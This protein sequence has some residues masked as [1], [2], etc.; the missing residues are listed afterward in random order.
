MGVLKAPRCV[1]DER[2]QRGREE[3]GRVHLRV[4]LQKNYTG[5]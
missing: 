4:S 5:N 2:A 1:I 3:D